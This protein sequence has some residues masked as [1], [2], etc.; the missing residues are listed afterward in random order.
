MTLRQRFA[1]R[2]RLLASALSP[3]SQ[4]SGNQFFIGKKPLTADDHLATYYKRFS[5]LP[6]ELQYFITDVML[7]RCVVAVAN[8]TIYVKG[9][10]T[11]LEATKPPP[12]KTDAK[13]HN[14]A[15]IKQYGWVKDFVDD[16]NKTVNLDNLIFS[17]ALTM[18]FYGRAAYE[19]VRDRKDIPVM[20]NALEVCPDRPDNLKPVIN[21]RTKKVVKYV[22]K[23]G[24]KEEV[25]RP[26]D[27]LYFVNLDINDSQYGLRYD[28]V[29][30]LGDV[31]PA[32]PA[33]ILRREVVL[34]SPRII[35]R[36]CD[37]FVI[38]SVNTTGFMGSKE[39]LTKSLNEVLEG[40]DSGENVVTNHEATTEAV[41]PTISLEAVTGYEKE[42]AN[43]IATTLGVPRI[44]VNEP[45]INRATSETE[46]KA[47]VEGQVAAKQRR[48]KRILEG[49]VWYGM[50]VRLAFENRNT[51]I[52]EG[53][54]VPV[55]VKQ[56]FRVI[57]IGDY[58]QEST[59]ASTLYGNGLGVL[60]EFP[61]Q[62][63][64]LAKLWTPEVEACFQQQHQQQ[65]K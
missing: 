42:K 6:L 4:A 52:K 60:G 43:E 55:S 30:A 26:E 20:L 59:V 23:R 10:D 7:R 41:Y 51:P 47:F 17:A 53:E 32:L 18:E 28:Q 19:I 50:L 2:M 13:T 56:N 31:T 15:L 39:E 64:K 5:I 45:N 34:T 25:Y 61:E 65:Q 9:F 27:V 33:C 37:P 62:A 38:I 3:F 44:L 21:E 12:D 1:G 16:I 63:L 54:A 57:D 58:T 8:F 35:K 46:M 11:K 29:Y 36:V 24:D 22:I 49:P 48:I 40:I 14:E